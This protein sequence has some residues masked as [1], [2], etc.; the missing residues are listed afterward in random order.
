MMEILKSKENE[1]EVVKDCGSN[2]HL[3]IALH[4]QVSVVQTAADKVQQMISSSQ[5]VDISLDEYKNVKM[6]CFGS[7]LENVKPCQILYKPLKFQQAQ[8]TAEPT[9]LNQPWRNRFYFLLYDDIHEQFIVRCDNKLSC[10]KL[11][12]TLVFS[13]DVSG[14]AGVTFD[15]QGDIYFGNYHTKNIQ[16][17]SPDGKTVNKC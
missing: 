14:R 10:V 11:D 3:F 2:N 16:R 1:I 6:K 12:G 5:E 8:I 7:L 4:E 13:M 17:I 9:H 15:R